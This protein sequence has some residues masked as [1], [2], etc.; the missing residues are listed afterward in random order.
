MCANVVMN[1]RRPLCEVE[2]LGAD[3]GL[4]PFSRHPSESDLDPRSEP[5]WTL[6]MAVA[7]V[8]FRRLSRVRDVWARY[9]D[10]CWDWEAVE[11]HSGPGYAALGGTDAYTHRGWFLRRR[12]RPTYVK[13]AVIDSIERQEGGS[14]G[15][16]SIAQATNLVRRALR[17]GLL[18]SSGIDRETGQSGLLG[19]GVAS[20]IGTLLGGRLGDVAPA[21]TMVVGFAV[22]MVLTALLSQLAANGWVV[23][24]LL[25]LIW[26]GGFSVVSSLQS[27][28]QREVNDAPNFASTLMNTGSQVGI[29]AGAALGGL[30]I[31]WGWNYGQLPLLS[32]GF[33]ALALVGTLLLVTS[34]RHRK[35]ALT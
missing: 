18:A 5:Y 17:E 16:M 35:P 10:E 28:L 21:A 15:V 30:V 12:R 7:W 9:T 24:I 31:T 32:A 34:D 29:A 4:E 8:A 11:W 1:V 25:F 2:R 3:R 33:A 13:M 22:L 20:F 23:A 19:T 6:T 27:R 26:V 14:T